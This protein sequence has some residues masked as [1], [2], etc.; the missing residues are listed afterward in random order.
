MGI[1]WQPVSFMR[2]ERDWW[3]GKSMK[4]TSVNNRVQTLTFN[5]VLKQLYHFALNFWI[6][7]ITLSLVNGFTSYSHTMLL[8]SDDL[9]IQ[10]CSLTI[11]KTSIGFI[12]KFRKIYHLCYKTN[13]W[14]MKAREFVSC[15]KQRSISIS[16]LRLSWIPISSI[17]MLRIHD[18]KSAV[19][20]LLYLYMF[21]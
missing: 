10:H 6:S 13:F 4:R 17:I 9:D 18:S 3:R 1:K 14:G 12:R 15:I 8:G 5:I 20:Y 7:V 19:M 2:Y 16:H 21:S 11:W